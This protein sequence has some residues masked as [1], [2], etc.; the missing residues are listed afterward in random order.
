M[1][2]S[3]TELLV[4]KEGVERLARATAVVAGL[5]G[6][7]G[8]AVEAMA[9][10]GIGRLILIDCDAVE[11]SNMNRQIIA[12]DGATGRPKVDV[13]RERVLAI[14]PG[15]CVVARRETIL[16]DNVDALLPEGTFYG[17]DAI[18]SVHSKVHL[19]AAF[20]RRA[21][22][23]VSCMGAASRLS[24]TGF[25]VADISDTEHCPLARAVRRRLKQLG[26]V[27]GVRCV[28]S[29]ENRGGATEPPEGAPLPQHG[30]RRIQGS[31]SYVP[32]IIGLMAAGVII[33]DILEF[34]SPPEPGIEEVHEP[35]DRIDP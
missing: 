30:K 9:R 23:F 14:N 6:V 13:A 35:L 26:I 7:G 20:R 12:I 1:R 33:Q 28:Y 16:P 31:I 22:G 34:S 21:R 15:A 3:R 11:L 24:P 27:R 2:F 17:I 29:R 10:A 25:V 19:I 4:G 18:D 32:G 8:Y 5:G